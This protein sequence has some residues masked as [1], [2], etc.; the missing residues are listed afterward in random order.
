M[1][2]LMTISNMPTFEP[3][4]PGAWELETTHFTR[5]MS[6][7]GQAP[8][9]EGFGPGFAESTARYGLLLD[10]ISPAISNDFVYQQ[11]VPFGA[12]KGAKGPPP[13]L[14]FQLITRLVPKLRA[15]IRTSQLAIENKQWRTD[16]KRWDEEVR[17]ASDK[18]HREL[19]AV[20]PATLSD[21]QLVKHLKAV[22][23][24]VRDMIKQHHIFTM[25][26]SVPVGD[27]VAHV[28]A[29]TG[30]PLGEILQ[31]LRGSSKISLGVAAD[32]LDTL[33]A[34]IRADAAAKT[35]LASTTS[36]GELVERLRVHDGAVGT[37][38]C[39]YLEIVSYRCLGYDVSAKCAI[40]MP[41]ILIRAIRA[42]VETTRTADDGGKART[43][44]LR[45]AIP[46]AHR[47]QFD[48]L[49]AEARF[50]NRLRDERGHYS[51]GWATG[52]ARRTLIEVGRRLVKR[53]TIDD[54]ELAVDA[55][56]EELVAM[57]GGGTEP[58]L[59][60]LERRAAWRT[61]TTVNDAGV[62]PWLGA[63]PSGPPPA[64]WLP[65]HG[66]RAQRAVEAF[67]GGLFQVPDVVRT[68]TSVTGLP[69]SP[70]VYEGRARLISG[71]EDFEKIQAGDVLVTRSTSPYFNVVLPLLGAIVT[72]R[73]GQLC[74]AAI[75]SREYGIPGVVGTREATQ[76]IKDGARVRV[77]G[78]TGQVTV[79][80]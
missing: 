2:S 11:A 55:S 23:D 45:E 66:R 30:K 71:E 9:I 58:G 1:V 39:A 47:A 53:G 31:V 27:L 34:A 13:K 25:S 16:L 8:M 56:Y 77:D 21:D 70:G 46:E 60:E 18:R 5:P 4:G 15:R 49:L 17:P 62:P 76:L 29:W 24:N 59:A 44:T 50:I 28:Q 69:V 72:D 73:G 43:A 63:P 51:D 22:R 80:G 65:A 61:T 79:L 42:A 54:P 68:A 48:E 33:T 36:A 67:L 10:R 57:L 14:I 7:F 37:A 12:P 26:C 19:Q 38:M 6:R 40:E 20:D 32:E 75:V 35:L 52:L 3:P 74:H 78:T 41:E 64:D